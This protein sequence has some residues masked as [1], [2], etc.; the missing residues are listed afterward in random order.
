MSERGR[1]VRIEGMDGSGKSTQLELARRF[2][3]DNDINAV[4]TREPGGTE[5]GV[6][7][8]E[9]LLHDRNHNLS[10]TVEASLL[11]AGRL[12][13]FET[14]ID[15]ALEEDRVVVSDRGYESSKIYQTT[16]DSLSADTVETISSLLLPR[17]YMRP[18]ALALLSLSKSTRVQ[19]LLERFKETAADK[20][21]SRSADFYEKV[22]QGYKELESQEYVTVID[23][24]RDAE[25]IFDTSMKQLI[26]GKYLPKDTHR[27]IID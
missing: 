16:G 7:L 17:R 12:H 20:I 24:E 8:R 23:A 14:V 15:P 22:F 10:P 27:T 21:E 4:F 2:S 19:R 25:E 18:D 5:L 26:F 13:L 6:Q 1:Y 9:M 3:I 11:T